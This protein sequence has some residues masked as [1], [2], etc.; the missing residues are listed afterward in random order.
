M[1]LRSYLSQVVMLLVTI[2]ALPLCGDDN[3]PLLVLQISEAALNR[4]IDET[5]ERETN[6]DDVI[7]ATHVVGSS[8]TTGTPQLH[9]V[10]CD[11]GPTIKV[12]F[13]GTT[14]SRTTGQH[15]PVVIYSRSQTDFAVEKVIAIEQLGTVVPSPTNIRGSTATVTENITTHRRG[16]LGKIILRR[17]AKAVAASEPEANA[18][19]QRDTERQIVTAFNLAVASQINKV[20]KQVSVRNLVAALLPADA[21]LDYRAV[22][23]GGY[24]TVAAFASAPT[25]GFVD[26]K[27]PKLPVEEQPVQIWLHKSIIGPNVIAAG[28]G[29][30]LARHWLALPTFLGPVTSDEHPR[31]AHWIT[32][33]DWFVVQLNRL[34]T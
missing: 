15:F 10:D 32:V 13:A 9:L 24:L 18:I 21:T 3:Q 6:V 17:A 22:T 5:I 31:G 11:A 8:K 14:V 1:F 4:L 28:I 30:E 16:V 27:L 19:S 25:V 2:V 34:E 12:I 33:D 29:V 23:E 20:K 26:L 7:L